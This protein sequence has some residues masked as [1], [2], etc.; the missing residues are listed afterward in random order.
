MNLDKAAVN[1]TYNSGEES[2]PGGYA[3]NSPNYKDGS[4]GSSSYAS[5]T[6]NF[7]EDQITVA[8]IPYSTFDFNRLKT[9]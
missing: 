2:N 9:Q 8:G 6:Y 7:L 5:A 4:F 3:N 1:I